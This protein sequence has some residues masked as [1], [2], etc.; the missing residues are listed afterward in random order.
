A[1]VEFFE[2]KIRPV[3]VQQCYECHSAEA[4]KNKKLR[5][6]LRLDT[7]DGVLTGGDSGP[8]VV[9]G[10]PADSVLLRALRHDGL[11][12][13]PKSKLP[14]A[15]VADFEKWVSL[16]AP[17]PRTSAAATGPRVID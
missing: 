2:K 14:D 8:A 11:R 10:K 4:Q 13:P 6:G 3:L 16:G 12:M 5:G 7:R 9:P 17:D 1:G 15:V